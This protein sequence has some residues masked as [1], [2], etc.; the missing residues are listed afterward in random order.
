MLKK[1]VG[2]IVGVGLL[3]VV[4]SASYAWDEPARGTAD[5]SE[6]MDAIRPHIEWSLGAPIEFVID[7]L[8]V[9]E[10]V[11]FASLAPQ[12]PG[13]GIIDLY[14]TPGYL[15]G[16]LYPDQMDGTSVSVL[17]RKSR[18]TWVAVHFAIG[19]TDVWFASPDYCVQYQPVIPEFC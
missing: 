17:Y 1:L 12:R 11:A 3:S 8:R 4:A 10:N 5:R 16:G 9:S 19:A 15:Q 18:N 7:Q 14:S 2:L 6:L 13:G